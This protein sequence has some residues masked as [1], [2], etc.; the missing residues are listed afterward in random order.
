MPSHNGTAKYYCPMCEGVESDE[1]GDCP[2]C[3]MA[4]E[5]R[6]G[7]GASHPE[8]DDMSKRFWWALALTIPVLI[9][10]M[11]DMIGDHPLSHLLGAGTRAW[12]ELAFATPVCL[13]AARPFFIRAAR[14]VA[15]RSLNMFTLI[16]LGV[17]VAYGYSLIASFAP[18]LFPAAFR[19]HDGA[20]PVYFEAASVIVTLILLGQV[21][22][23]RARSQT[24]A[25]IRELLALA[26]VL[27]TRVRADGS[28][29]SVALD[30]VRVGDRLLV[31]PGEKIPVDGSVLDGASSVDES[32]L[33]G[34]PIPVEKTVGARVAGATIN[35]TGALV[36]VA[37]KVG[38][39]TLLARIVALVAEAQRSRAPVQRLADR[40]AAVFVPAVIVI[41]MATFIVWA[42]VG[43]DPRFAHALLAAVAVLIIA[44]PCALGL[45]TPMSIM[46]ATGRGA[47]MGILF[48][49]AEAIERL[50]DV[51]VLL[52]DKT[53]TLTEGRPRLSAI[54]AA[55]GYVENEVL[56][57]VADLERASEHPLARAIVD[58]AQARGIA[59]GPVNDFASVTGQGVTGVVGGRSVA[60]GNNRLM[61]SLGVDAARL[62]AARFQE[63]GAT[64]MY[65]AIDGNFA[66]L[67]AVAD[68]I[69]ATSAEAV[70]SLRAEGI[71]LVM[72]TGDSER[73]AHAVAAKL[74][75]AEVVADASPQ[76]KLERVRELKAEGLVVAMAGDGIND[77]PALA[78]ADVGIAMGTG[79][80]VAMATAA[81]TLVKGDLKGIVRAHRLSHATLANIRQNLF[82][83][84]VYN[85]VG[86]PVAAGVLYPVWGLL[87]SPMIA[88]AAMSAS[89]ISVI[90]NALR[91]RSKRI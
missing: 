88:A 21:L 4:L 67:V 61:K 85:G 33:S 14:S 9:L 53:G 75:I 13:W 15:N 18:E 47:R 34:E 59:A 32:M 45:A 91:L 22:E 79:T 90:G 17:G 42:M 44:C 28:Y 71:R 49:N 19:G 24:G 66:G 5:A 72:L 43:P 3:G 73:T 41:A 76:R 68:P 54:V 65:C 62:D 63:E 2:K 70:A 38:S 10:S 16:G 29:E 64:V 11:G 1:P 23:L 84:F 55:D 50:R 82:F 80:D 89:S 8:L 58:A 7:D 6:V 77:A 74:G 60:F 40:V 25:A 26:P 83:A 57:C 27:A 39:E 46:V 30:A 69:K 12:L 56:R 78:A 87:L 51:D 20:V 31:R 52:I 35:G 48:R 81:V 36:M 37:E 86:V